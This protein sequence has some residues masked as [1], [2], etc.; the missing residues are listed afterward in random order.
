MAVGP[1]KGNACRNRSHL[2]IVAQNGPQKSQAVHTGTLCCADSGGVDA[3][4][5]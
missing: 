2:I 4:V 3:V 5:Y 1:Y